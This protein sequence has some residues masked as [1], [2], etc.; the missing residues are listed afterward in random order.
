MAHPMHIHG[1][2]FFVL[3]RD[4][5]PPPPEEAGAKDVVLVDAG[6][7]VRV[8]AQ[9]NHTTEG[10]PYMYH[11]HN[12]MHEDNMMMLQFIV[13]DPNVG[14]AEKNETEQVT[15]YPNPSSGLVQFRTS[16]G[17]RS[18]EV[19]DNLGRTVL[20]AASTGE[21]T[22]TVDFGSLPAGVYTLTLRNGEKM[23]RTRT[24]LD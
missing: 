3:D 4:G 5:V 7:T 24:V 16:F 21:R 12:L 6:E 11:C 13:V 23:V 17:V 20:Q 2:S 15:V 10:W 22:G 8:I 18:V 9:Y 19:T 14:L 1:C